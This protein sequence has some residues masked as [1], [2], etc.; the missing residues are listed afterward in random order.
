MTIIQLSTPKVRSAIH[1]IRLSGEKSLAFLKERIKIK[2]TIKPR[3]VYYTPFLDSHQKTIDQ[4][5]CYYFQSPHSYTGEDMVEIHC[6]GSLLIVNQILKEG[7]HF[8]LILAEKGEFTKRAFLNGKINIEQ[9]EAIDILIKSNSNYNKENAL[10]ILEKKSSFKFK[11]IQDNLLQMIAHLESSI[12]FPEEDIPE[13]EID[14]QELYRDY[15]R[16]L[17]E[18]EYYFDTIKE[19]YQKG[20]KTE[21]G[22][23]VAIAGMPNAGKS[24]LLNF[25]LREDRALVSDIAGTTRDYIQ[26]TI[27]LEGMPLHLYDTAGVRETI[28]YLEQKSIQKTKDILK[29][30]DLILFL[31][32]DDE[33]IEMLKNLITQYPETPLLLYVNKEDTMSTGQKDILLK[34]IAD[35]LATSPMS[36]KKSGQDKI[37]LFSLKADKKKS[38]ESVEKDL[39]MYIKN[40]Y[41]IN[42]KELALLNERQ[43]LIIAKLLTKLKD[44]KLFLEKEES[45]EIICENF[46]TCY[47]FLKEINIE[48]DN[49]SVFDSL[50]NQFCI[51]K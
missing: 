16:Q 44:I 27:W 36:H 4:V 37:N 1:I 29:N 33:C 8:G 38:I 15:L 5:V 9:A 34:K 47:D 17:T 39:A 12:E 48:I 43:S 31:I 2:E 40:N 13:V 26:E 10:K 50:F 3:K 51:G 21:E 7:I 41:D 23:Q 24:T 14:K 32:F 19:N 22:L 30:A 25:L 35:V 28:D 6:H 11:D 49:E 42:N 18:I 45:E 20:K 46:Y